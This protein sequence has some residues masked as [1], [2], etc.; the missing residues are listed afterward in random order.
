MEKAARIYIK[1]G[2]IEEACK[3]Y[4]KMQAMTEMHDLTRFYDWKKE[5]TKLMDYIKEHKTT[6]LYDR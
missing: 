4:D 2:K 1:M 3:L 5:Q 6:I